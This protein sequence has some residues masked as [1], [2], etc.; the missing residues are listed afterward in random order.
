MS[1]VI[2]STIIQS[3]VF[4]VEIIGNINYF[5]ASSLPSHTHNINDITFTDEQY[6]TYVTL[7]N[8]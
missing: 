3:V 7:L 1:V 2:E 4:E 5:D 6:N 8:S